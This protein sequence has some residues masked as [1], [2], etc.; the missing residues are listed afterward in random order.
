M[1]TLAIT[2]RWNPHVYGFGNNEDR[3]DI[4]ILSKL[5]FIW[6]LGSYPLQ[7]HEFDAFKFLKESPNTINNVEY[8]E[9][10]WKQNIYLNISLI[11]GFY[12]YKSRMFAIPNKSFEKFVKKVKN[13]YKCK[14]QEKKKV[15]NL[16]NRQI[17]GKYIHK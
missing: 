15:K 17:Y 16:L 13:I 9:E 8:F 11:K 7:R 14:I 6:E 5:I 12:T 10:T 1:A 4:K 2:S 3:N